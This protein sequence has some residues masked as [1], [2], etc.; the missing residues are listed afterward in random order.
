MRSDILV[1]NKTDLAPYV[2]A[3]V[4]MM[5]KEATQVRN[6]RTV[7]LTNCKTGEGIERLVATSWHTTYCSRA[8][9]DALA[10]GSGLAGGARTAPVLAFAKDGRGR[11]F[12]SRQYAGYP[13]HVCKTLY[14]DDALPG[15]G[16]IYTQSS[17]GGLYEH[18]R[19]AI[20][21]LSKA[22]A[23]AHVTTPGLDHRAQHGARHAEQD[24]LHPGGA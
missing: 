6:G 3:D 23:Q 14:E 5:L 24:N 17:A 4:G 1:I 19:H 16:T 2:G 13:F 11:T 7:L 12:L 15:M 18:D 10:A 21:I 8:E 9:H 20:E 22:G